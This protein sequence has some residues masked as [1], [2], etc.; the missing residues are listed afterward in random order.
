MGY[1]FGGG[2]GT[3]SQPKRNDLVSGVMTLDDLYTP[4]LDDFD[5][6][7]DEERSGGFHRLAVGKNHLLILPPTRRVRD[8]GVKTP[9]VECYRHYLRDG[10]VQKWLGLNE[11][12]ESVDAEYVCDRETFGKPCVVCDKV[13][14]L[15]KGA[16]KRERAI[17]GK[18]YRTRKCVA[19]IVV[20][21]DGKQIV[22]PFTFGES[23]RLPLARALK[24]GEIFCD[25]AGLMVIRIIRTGEMKRTRYEVKVMAKEKTIPIRPEWVVSMFDLTTY[26][27]SSLARDDANDVFGE[28]F[29]SDFGVGGDDDS[30]SD[31]SRFGVSRGSSGFDDDQVPF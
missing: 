5:D 7:D 23:I 26:L 9:W 1:T 6:L 19:N 12:P 30:D 25:P 8:S 4:S 18:W 10:Q 15:K 3:G 24:D 22:K 21:A 13:A 27:P 17:G 16:T 14:V 2:S 11:W 29:S 20:S 28:L 31:D